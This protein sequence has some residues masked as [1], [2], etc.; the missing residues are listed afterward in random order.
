ME[1]FFD[2]VR[3]RWPAGREDLHVHILPPPEISAVLFEH[4]RDL[5]HRDPLVPVGPEWLHVT[6]LHSGPMAEW[7]PGEVE[8][9]VDQLGTRLA[10]AE[11]VTLTLHR[12]NVGAVA[13]ECS[14]T[15]GEPTRQLWR[16]CA[17]EIS[18]V[19]GNRFPLIPTVHYPHASIAYST[20]KLAE[21]AELKAWLSDH[22]TD[23]LTFIA[24]RVAVVAQQH[25]E[26]EITW[27][28][29]AELPLGGAA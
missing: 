10:D 26:R 19:T 25:D 29:L 12:P 6:L 8:A 27:R 23:P 17:E 14:C 4:Y 13:L 22:H 16:A 7:H 3:H 15:P 20:G 11:P 5:T 18:S 9:L 24:H 21:R 2:R 28:L 1:S